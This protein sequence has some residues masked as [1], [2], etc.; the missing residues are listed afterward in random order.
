MNGD[1]DGFWVRDGYGD[2]YARR[3][4]LD[5]Q[6]LDVDVGWDFELGLRA[7]AQAVVLAAEAALVL[8][9]ASSSRPD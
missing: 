6:C 9:G 1:G 3:G 7:K 2:E 4:T 5:E 8:V